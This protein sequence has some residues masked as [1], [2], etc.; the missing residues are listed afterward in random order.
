MFILRGDMDSQ[1]A[2]KLN[3]LLATELP[4]RVLLDVKDMTLVDRAALRF[5]TGAECDRVRNINCPPYVHS[6]VL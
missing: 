1:H 6:W 5:L 4:G 3:E 2:A